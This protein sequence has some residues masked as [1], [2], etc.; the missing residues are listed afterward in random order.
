V[1]FR[2]TSLKGVLLIEPEKRRDE[3]GFFART[4]CMREFEAQGL[5]TTY[6]QHNMSSTLKKGTLRGMHFQTGPHAEIKVIRCL[7]GAACDILLDMRPES[8]TYLKWEAFD[9]NDRTHNAVY[10]PRGVAHG[11]QTLTDDVEMS[12]LHSDY[13]APQSEGAVRWND[14]AFG[15][16]WP[17]PPTVMSDKDRSYPD[18]TPHGR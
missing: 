11:F 18:Y 10:A 5:E 12:Y 7:R 8:P 2:E 16:V 13:Y 17:A 6:V 1:I 15:I 3:R 14:P 9:L 4:F